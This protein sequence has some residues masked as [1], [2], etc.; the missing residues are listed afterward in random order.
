[1]SDYPGAIDSFTSK[2]DNVD[3]I[4]AIDVNEL[5]LGITAVQ[6]E[7]GVNPAGGYT[8]VVDRLDALDSSIGSPSVCKFITNPQAVYAQRAQVVLL[9][10][11]AALTITRIHIH[12]NDVSPTAEMAGDLKF[13]D[14]VATGGFANATVIDVCDTT[15]GVFTATSSFDDATVPSGKY[16]YWQFDASPHADWK[17]F[18]IEIYYT[19]D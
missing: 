15:N 4:N 12:G 10:A 2:V 6:T 7:L 19:F 5:Q 1:M 18:Y 3:A 13:A 17:D 14:D 8:T 16:I 9:R 11:P